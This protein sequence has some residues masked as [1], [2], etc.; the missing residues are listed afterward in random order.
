MKS[1]HA[2]LIFYVAVFGLLVSVFI[3]GSVDGIVVLFGA[4]AIASI[5]WY[6]F[7]ETR[8][9]EKANKTFE[10]YMAIFEKQPGISPEVDNSIPLCSSCHQPMDTPGCCTSPESKIKYPNG[11][12]TIDGGCGRHSQDL[13]PL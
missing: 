3:R 11:F 12:H 5:F 2:R 8:E 1:K 6:A 4:I 10:E 13:H 7:L 9:I